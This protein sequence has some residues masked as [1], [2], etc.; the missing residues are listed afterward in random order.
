MSEKIKVITFNLRVAVKVDGVNYF[1]NRLP[2][3]IEFLKAE[4]PDVVGFQEVNAHMKELLNQNIEDY[5]LVGC[6][7][8]KD[9]NGESALIGYRKDKFEL[10]KF[11]NFWL[12]ATPDVPGSRYGFDQSCCPRIT[13]AALLKARSGGSSQS[14]KA[15]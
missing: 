13:S 12:S 6:G 3:I 9:Y 5:V 10:I 15:C 8:E 11:E 1:D 7:R 2:R 4:Q 14:G